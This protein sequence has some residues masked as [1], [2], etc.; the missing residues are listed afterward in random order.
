[1]SEKLK[2]EATLDTSNFERNAKELGGGIKNVTA[3]AKA[4]AGAFA[5][6]E[7]IDFLGKAYKEAKDAEIATQK[8]TSALGKQSKILAEQANAMQYMSRATDDEITSMQAA[9]A[10]YVKSEDAIQ[11][12]TPAILDMAEATGTDLRAAALQVGRAIADDSEELGRYKIAIDGAAGSNDR[13]QSV[14]QGLNDKFGGQAE[15][16]NKA[17]GEIENLRKAYENWLEDVGKN[18]AP[19]VDATAKAIKEMFFSSGMSRQE[20]LKATVRDANKEIETYQKL[21][22]KGHTQYLENLRQANEKK[23]KA[24]LEF[25]SST[26]TGT[27]KITGLTTDTTAATKAAKEAAKKAA[28]DAKKASEELA[29]QNQAFDDEQFL[30]DQKRQAEHNEKLL[31]LAK[32]KNEEALKLDKELAENQR[33]LDEALTNERLANAERLKKADRE[34]MESDFA[35]AQ[36]LISTSGNVMSAMA[37]VADAAG[38][39]AEEMKAL[40]IS[41]ALIDGASASV[42]M[43]RSVWSGAG[44]PYAAIAIGA[45]NQ[46]AIAATTAANVAIISQQKFAD[47]GIVSGPT[48]GDMTQ[49]RANGGEMIL[50]REHQMNLLAMANGRGGGGGGI[51]INAGITMQGGGF[52]TQQDARKAIAMQQRQLQKTLR[53]MGNNGRLRRSGVATV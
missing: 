13:A 11:K 34:K 32:E 37:S 47:G 39:D 22:D 35:Y 46:A 49:V 36:S 20:I 41:M 4:L 44:N 31:E 18:I 30:A 14:L 24:M 29:K 8:L 26:P 15:A 7:A 27:N 1:V 42:A 9:L 45:I 52:A 51:T 23:K 16:A 38:K 43:W 2:F 12:L 28:E 25:Y 10:S 19:A 50:T 48:G 33:L 5:A 3:A 6:V 40:K 17:S 21:V 53:Y